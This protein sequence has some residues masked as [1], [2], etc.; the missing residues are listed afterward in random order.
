MEFIE[1]R[2]YSLSLSLYLFIYSTNHLS[3][4][5]FIHLSIHQST[6]QPIPIQ[7]IFFFFISF[8]QFA[9][10]MWQKTRLNLSSGTYTPNTTKHR[11]LP[12][13]THLNTLYSPLMLP[14]C[15][16][17]LCVAVLN[18]VFHSSVCFLS[19]VQ[20]SFYGKLG[21]KQTIFFFVFTSFSFF[22]FVVV[23]II[24]LLFIHSFIHFMS[25]FVF[26]LY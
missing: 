7:L 22:V 6:S 25:V 3:I 14:L 26:H 11:A 18:F 10:H 9:F 19:L 1:E 17:F 2:R 20:F 4:Y 5:L 12:P 21:C 15:F 24:V 16:H 13:S 23:F 8:L